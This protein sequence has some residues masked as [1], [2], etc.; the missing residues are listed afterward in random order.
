MVARPVKPLEQEKNIEKMNEKV[1]NFIKQEKERLDASQKQ[2]ESLKKQE[3][4][5]HL[6]SL[7][8]IGKSET[9]IE[10]RYLPTQI[11]SAKFDSET[12]RYYLEIEQKE[13]SAL[14]VTDEEYEEICKYSPPIV[15]DIPKEE[16]LK[17]KTAAEQTLNTI[18]NIVLVCGII[19]AFVCLM[20]FG[21]E[22][23]FGIGLI[24]SIGILITTLPIWA[25]LRI[26]CEIAMNVRNINNNTK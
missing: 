21:A 15:A 7:G 25:T 14:E 12:N 22:E 18:A 9:R 19:C 24:I 8:L 4:D 26:I 16:I 23:S 10:R 2:V 20:V 6:I 3:R 1:A 13:V 17:T 11:D 5:K